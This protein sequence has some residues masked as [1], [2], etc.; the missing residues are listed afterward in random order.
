MKKIENLKQVQA[1]I[2]ET[3]MY[4]VIIAVAAVVLAFIIAQLIKWGGGKHDTS[5]IKRRVWF[6]I[7]GIVASAA[8]FLYNALYVSSFITKAPLQA[9]FS[10]GNIYATLAL[11]GVYVIAGIVTMMILR[12]SKWGSILGQ[13]KR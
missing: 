12:R 4:A 11:L 8:F 1:L 9:K 13:S 10:N 2:G 6:I 5:H 3:Y 7:V